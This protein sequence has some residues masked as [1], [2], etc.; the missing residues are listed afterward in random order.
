MLSPLFPFVNSRAYRKV[1]QTCAP[2]F[3][4]VIRSF[5]ESARPAPILV[6]AR[7]KFTRHSMANG[8]HTKLTSSGPSPKSCRTER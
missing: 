1:F 6:H 5:F 7:K 8:I 4:R 3:N 2:V